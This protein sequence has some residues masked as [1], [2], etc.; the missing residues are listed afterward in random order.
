MRTI[1]ISHE[2]D[3]DGVA[4]AVMLTYALLQRDKQKAVFT[5]FANY[6]NVDEIV[7]QHARNAD[8]IF[9]SDL[10]LR[11]TGLS[12]FWNHLPADRVTIIDHHSQTS[13]SLEAW[14][15]TMTP[16]FDDSGSKCATD[17]VFENFVIPLT[18]FAAFKQH[19]ELE[20]L[21]QIT[22]STDLFL[23]DEPLSMPLSDIVTVLG[24]DT[25]YNMFLH[26]LRTN[27]VCF[28]DDSKFNE[29]MR[30]AVMTAAVRRLTSLD[31]ARKT[32]VHE[33]I[34][35]SQFQDECSDRPVV[36]ACIIQ[37]YQTDVGNE[38]RKQYPFGWIAMLDLDRH[39][40]SFRTNDETIARTGVNVRDIAAKLGGG[41]HPCASGAPI[42]V[43]LYKGGSWGLLSKI[44]HILSYMFAEL[45]EC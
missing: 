21:C 13:A 23:Q 42:S 36:S 45:E 27:E 26:Q 20:R 44:T 41:G 5:V 38:I 25:V 3:L 28:L 43:D 19:G 30:L 12:A 32:V 8:E 31:L 17:L 15:G 40:I 18:S 1:I 11:N 34:N 33:P 9:I 22:H 14:K 4:S 6:N 29:A 2:E 10:C 37:G 35:T 7:E 16:I 24:A 39:Q